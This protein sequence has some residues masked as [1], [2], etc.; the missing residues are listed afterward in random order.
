[1]PAYSSLNGT[2]REKIRRQKEKKDAN[3]NNNGNTKK[4]EG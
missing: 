4:N 1:M 2:L 3:E